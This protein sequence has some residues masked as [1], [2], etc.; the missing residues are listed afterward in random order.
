[1]LIKFCKFVLILLFYQSP[2][3][4]KSKTLND[5]NSR[6]LSNYLS[7]IVAY[8]NQDNSQA[9]KFFKSSKILI[10]Q[11]NPY[12]EKYIYS[13]ILEGKVHHAINEIKQNLTKN[14]S[15]FFEAHLLLALDSLRKKNYIK[16]K[17]HLK[18]ANQ[19]INND[20]FSLI[21]YETLI[22][23]LYVFE[24]NKI[25]KKKKNFGNL[26]FINEVF[27]R[28]YLGD[29][30]TGVFFDQLINNKNSIDYSR[31]IFFYIDYL[32]DE[33]KYE[34]AK[35]ISND[36]DDLNT[37]LLIS[38]GKKWIDEKNLEKFEKFFSCKNPNDIVSEFFFLVGNLH[39]SQNNYD[40]SNFYLNI[41]HFF[42][43]KFI[44]NL[45]LSAENYYLNEDY[46]KTKSILKHFNKKDNFYYW[47]RLKKEAQIISKIKNDEKSLDFIN[48]K[49]KEIEDPSIKIIFDIANFNKSAKKYKKAIKFYNQI[50]S[51][52]SLNSTLYSEV[53]YRRGSSYERLGDYKNSDKD[54]L[55]SLEINPDD[56]YVLNYL[57]YSW[58]E[59]DY[60]IDTALKMLERAFAIKSDDAYIIDSVGWAY[61]L[62]GDYIKAE[63]FLKRAVELMPQDYTVNDHYGDILWKLKRKIQARYFW[64]NVLNLKGIEDNMRKNI[65]HKLIDGLKNS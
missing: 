5:F 50:I 11:H 36:L 63:K 48:T 51:K 39:A 58:L 14:N 38:Q 29:K 35:L 44:F 25:L 3:Y 2:L 55:E 57:G 24:E 6:Y 33:N 18:D 19:F 26:S 22:E 34:E 4:S 56:A 10:K 7:G 21:T 45:S 15:N 23:Y 47:F 61:Y 17:K 28:C 16:S 60:K 64:K 43:P 20:R 59:R 8:D 37:P 30:N 40:Q 1:M 9:L 42:N 53:L 49:F 52:I 54:L 13:L 65:N 32:I 62:I 41:A 31:Y 46:I 12:L 27:Q